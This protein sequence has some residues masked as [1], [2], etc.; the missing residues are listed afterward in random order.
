MSRQTSLTQMLL[1][2]RLRKLAMNTV[3]TFFSWTKLRSMVSDRWENTYS[4]K[5]KASAASHAKLHAQLTAQ[6]GVTRFSGQI[7]L[8][9][10]G[11]RMKWRISREGREREGAKLTWS[12]PLLCQL[13]SSACSVPSEASELWRWPGHPAS[14]D[15][16]CRQ[17][18]WALSLSLSLVHS[19][20]LTPEA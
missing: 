12:W 19:Y 5:S 4:C 20:T 6:S 7:M 17:R 18:V 8:R 10:R 16:H 1:L 14:N 3:F 9:E 11:E 15:L 2:E 13:N